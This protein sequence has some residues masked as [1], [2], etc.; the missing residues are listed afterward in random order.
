[1]RPTWWFWQCVISSKT[2]TTKPA[3][4]AAL[5]VPCQWHDPWMKTGNLVAKPRRDYPFKAAAI[6]LSTAKC[7]SSFRWAASI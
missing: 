3:G 4:L 2:T 5:R 6:D 7:R 1:M